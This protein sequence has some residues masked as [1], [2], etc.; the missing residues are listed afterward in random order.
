M[1]CLR[2]QAEKQQTWRQHVLYYWQNKFVF[3]YM[4]GL[5]ESVR[6]LSC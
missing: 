1:N 2:E 3:D 4:F 6:L 5:K